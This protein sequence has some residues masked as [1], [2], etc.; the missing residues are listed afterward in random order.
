MPTDDNCQ[1]IPLNVITAAGSLPLLLFLLLPVSL[2]QQAQLIAL[3]YFIIII[4]FIAGVDWCIAC[5]SS[6]SKLLVWAISLS[7][8]AWGIVTLTV[9]FKMYLLAW[10]AGFILLNVAGIIDQKIYHPY[11]TLKHCRLVGT[12]ALSAVVLLIILRCLF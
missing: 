4:A 6:N 5:L 8:L 12:I 11:P 10:I 2:W 3:V 7:L 9:L 1:Q